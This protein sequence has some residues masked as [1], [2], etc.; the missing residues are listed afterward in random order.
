MTL[1]N[2][3]QGPE[4]GP[5][6][7][8]WRLGE[9]LHHGTVLQFTVFRWWH[10]PL[11]SLYSMALGLALL[12]VPMAALSQFPWDDSTFGQKLMIL[13][14]TS[15]HNISGVWMLVMAVA[16]WTDPHMLK[17]DGNGGLILQSVVRRRHKAIKDIKTVVLAQQ[18][19]DERG[20]DTLGIRIKFSGSKLKL[21]FFA[22][23]EE[24]LKTLKAV[25]PAIVIET[26]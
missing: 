1:A 2:T 15:P 6:E 9:N 4:Q 13:L 16:T 3:Q 21:P 12:G 26:V 19:N 5:T 11:L 14:M 7:K 23:R 24:F 18:K 17:F 25:H 20:D 10:T 8:T 22:E